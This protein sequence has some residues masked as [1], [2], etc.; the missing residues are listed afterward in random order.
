MSAAPNT[1]SKLSPFSRSKRETDTLT[2]ILTLISLFLIVFGTLAMVFLQ[3]YF[4]EESFDLRQQAIE[5]RQCNESCD[6]N[7]QCEINHFCYQGRCRLADN[8]T[9]SDCEGVPDQGLNFGCDHYCA[10]SR[11]CAGEFTCL[12]NHCRLPDNPDDPFCRPST[13]TIQEK[14]SETCNDACASHADCS[15]NMRCYGGLCRLASHPSN[16]DCQP[17][18]TVT[19]PIRQ[20]RP[21][22][23]A[24]PSLK[25]G[26][27]ATESTAATDSAQPATPAA[28]IQPSPSPSPTTRPIP[29]PLPEEET[30][31]DAVI[32][33]LRDWGVPV[34]TLP[35][36]AVAAGAILLLLVLI[37]KIIDHFQNDEL[38]LSSSATTQ[39]T[40]PSQK[41]PTLTTDRLEHPVQPQS[42]M[43]NRLKEK[44]IEVPKG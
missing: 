3:K 34:N 42:S 38:D 39:R 22:P 9:N 40:E 10:D 1:L 20:P 26:P 13:E 28:I 4:M 31:L 25:G 30:A 11:E 14:I 44:K 43:V 2:W 19:T 32:N 17:Q 16:P 33:S 8:P 5:I 23:T 35:I 18:T 21:S 7:A 24:T 6:S 37:P 15:I 29:T 12:E 36:I 41:P 27:E